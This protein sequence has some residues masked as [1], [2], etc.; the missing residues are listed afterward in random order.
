MREG[1]ERGRQKGM[2]LREERR[3]MGEYIKCLLSVVEGRVKR[4]GDRKVCAQ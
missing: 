2:Y 3:E 1:E 4:E